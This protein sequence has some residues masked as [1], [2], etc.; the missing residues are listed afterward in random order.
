MNIKV[1]KFGGSSVKNSTQIK[2]VL[3]IVKSDK[4]RKV[5]IVS[6]A[7]RDEKFDEKITDHLLNLATNGNYFS[8]HKIDIK[9][10]ESYEAIVKKYETLC[11]DLKIDKKTNFR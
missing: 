11:N 8:E 1:C 5:I 6:A 3:D 9:A 7:G 4:Q 10:K 2:K